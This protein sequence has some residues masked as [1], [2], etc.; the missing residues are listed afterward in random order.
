MIRNTV[1]DTITSY[2]FPT[3]RFSF[4]DRSLATRG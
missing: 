3:R 2:D 1:Q 4:R